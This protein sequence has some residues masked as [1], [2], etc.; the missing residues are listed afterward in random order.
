MEKLNPQN[1]TFFHFPFIFFQWRCKKCCVALRCTKKMNISIKQKNIQNDFYI[2][3]YIYINI[4]FFLGFQR[5]KCVPDFG[6]NATQRN[7]KNEMLPPKEER[8]FYEKEEG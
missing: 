5:G 1:Q 7:T 6:C 2:Y 3:I 8:I 4:N